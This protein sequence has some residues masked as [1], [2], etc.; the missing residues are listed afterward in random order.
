MDSSLSLFLHAVFQDCFR[1][2]FRFSCNT[3]QNCFFL[4]SGIFLLEADLNNC[5]KRKT[6]SLFTSHC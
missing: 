6:F 2:H 1:C 3:L 4:F 5:G